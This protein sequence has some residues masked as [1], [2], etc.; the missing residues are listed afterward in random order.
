MAT[1]IQIDNRTLELLK[2]YKEQSKAHSYDE[3]ILNFMK[4]GSYAKNFRGFLGKKNMTFVMK[5]LRDKGD[6]F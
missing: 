4:L 2:K 3:V 5:G 6:R 1:T